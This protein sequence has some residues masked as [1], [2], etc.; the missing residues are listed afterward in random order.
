MIPN[1]RWPNVVVVVGEVGFVVVERE[2]AFGAV[3]FRVDARVPNESCSNG[4][5]GGWSCYLLKYY[6][7]W[8]VHL[9]ERIRNCY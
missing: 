1:V 2:C 6:R 7:C 5:G 3:V 4:S 9:V 8:D